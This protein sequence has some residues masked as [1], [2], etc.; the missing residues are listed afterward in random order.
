MRSKPDLT[1]NGE[2]K[3][4]VDSTLIGEYKTIVDLTLNGESQKSVHLKN[5][6]TALYYE[7]NDRKTYNFIKFIRVRAYE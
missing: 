6:V 1:L 7:I 4:M 2:S 5:N 3:T